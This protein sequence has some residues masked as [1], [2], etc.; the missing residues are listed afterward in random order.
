MSLFRL[1]SLISH[2][3]YFLQFSRQ[4]EE[5]ACLPVLG[6]RPSGWLIDAIYRFS[7]LA[8]TLSKDG[9]KSQGWVLLDQP[10]NPTC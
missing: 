1:P 8:S 10:L 4:R 7:L 5:T 3:S 2:I 6:F 9:N